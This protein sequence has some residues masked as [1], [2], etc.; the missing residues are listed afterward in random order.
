MFCVVN[1]HQPTEAD[2]RLPDMNITYVMI[3]KH[4]NS[5]WQ[6]FICMS[7]HNVKKGRSDKH[8][9]KDISCVG[10]RTLTESPE[11]GLEAV[12]LVERRF[13]SFY[14]FSRPST[15]DLL[16]LCLLGGN[17]TVEK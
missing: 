11:R 13:A 16:V 10:V 3:Y 12:C 9:V 2:R 6:Y 8:N 15:L 7:K 5:I 1:K 4:A 17:F 14:P